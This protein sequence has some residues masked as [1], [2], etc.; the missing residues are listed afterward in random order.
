MCSKSWPWASTAG[1]ICNCIP[2][3]FQTAPSKPAWLPFRTLH[4][5]SKEIVEEF[6][7]N[8]MI[9]QVMDGKKS[10]PS[11]PARRAVIQVQI[12]RLPGKAA[13]QES[14]KRANR[15][16]AMGDQEMRRRIRRTQTAGTSSLGCSTARRLTAADSA[17]A[18]SAKTAE[19]L[20]AEA[21]ASPDAMPGRL[22]TTTLRPTA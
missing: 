5:S 12:A 6:P 7:D 8:Q 1:S 15:Q 4:M 19:E 2:K 3:K 9:K 21:A 10:M 17:A 11:D 14:R 22:R 18:D 20:A 16:P 13:T